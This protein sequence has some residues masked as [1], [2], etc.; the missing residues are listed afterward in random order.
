MRLIASAVAALTKRVLLGLNVCATD[1]NALTWPPAQE[2]DENSLEVDERRCKSSY[3]KAW[4]NKRQCG[5]AKNAE[6]EIRL[7]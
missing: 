7:C 3:Y 5:P 4:L 6:K 1:I 2:V